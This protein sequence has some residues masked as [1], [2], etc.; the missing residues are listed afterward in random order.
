MKI[1]FKAPFYTKV[2]PMII[3]LLL[4][5]KFGK[6]CLTTGLDNYYQERE[7]VM[8]EY[9]KIDNGVDK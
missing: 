3:L 8:Q 4:F 9:W 5:V 7:A 2:L 6:Y 1:N